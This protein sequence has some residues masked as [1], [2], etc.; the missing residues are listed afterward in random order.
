[1]GSLVRGKQIDGGRAAEA[2]SPRIQSQAA[3]WQLREHD[4]D[5]ESVSGKPLAAGKRRIEIEKVEKVIFFREEKIFLNQPVG[6]QGVRRVGDDL[7]LG[8]KA[9]RRNG[10]LGQ[11]DRSLRVV[12]QDRD[13]Q[14][15]G[16][17]HFIQSVHQRRLAL[18]K[19]A[20]LAE[21][22][23]LHRH[24]RRHPY[25]QHGGHD[26][27]VQEFKLGGGFERG[28]LHGQRPQSDRITG[29]KP[30]GETTIGLGKQRGLRG[31][32]V[33]CGQLSQF[34]VDIEPGYGHRRHGRDQMRVE[35]AQQRRCDFG[36]F[37]V[38]AVLDST[39]QEGERF[40]EPFYMGVGAI[41]GRKL[42]PRGD[43]GIA[44]EKVRAIRR[45]QVSSEL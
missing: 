2:E 37:F 1:M 18:D 13:A 14:R 10:I 36:K 42:E 3:R 32:F 20:Q 23:F 41:V 26:G 12:R 30:A 43:A 24:S 35:N 25:A 19:K 27:R 28:A 7:V 38:E 21:I 5:V 4:Q 44:P 40:E 34:R 45:S 33:T 22:Q 39:S 6:G 11:I 15:P 9:H 17:E 8:A 16:K 31:H 29:A